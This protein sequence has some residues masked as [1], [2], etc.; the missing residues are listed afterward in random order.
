MTKL[1]LLLAL[2]VSACSG[3]PE[4]ALAPA[5]PAPAP[6]DSVADWSAAFDAEGAVGTFV[7]LD[8]ATGRTIRHDPGRAATR[9]TPA[10]TSKIWNAL[11]FL[12]Q[13]TVTNVDVMHAWD[14]VERQIRSWNRDHSLRTG[15]ENS[16]LWLFQR[17][18]LEVG[19][20]GYEA[21]LARE[22][23]GNATMSDSL[24]M[25]WLDGTLRV[26]ADEQVVFFDR[27]RRGDL[28]FSEAHQATVRELLPTLAE[29]GGARLRGKTG[30][31][32]PPDEPAIGWLVGWV[33]RPEGTPGGPGQAVVYAMNAE[34][35]PGARFDIGPG[36]L[37]IVRAV[38]ADAGVWP[39]R[40]DG[41]P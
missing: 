33:E 31:G 29:S 18:A 10:S 38:L 5:T 39:V 12:D 15:V 1:A 17:L 7:L 20:D 35:A 2:A 26:S 27:L 3:S 30:W 21:V 19:R 36:R 14:G 34:A 9:L 13:G 8:T 32:I 22:P 40:T 25:S 37:R 23:Y 41:A 24:D 4:P 16:A 11:V 28:A 6:A